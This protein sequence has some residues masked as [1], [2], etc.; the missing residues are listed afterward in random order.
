MSLHTEGILDQCRQLQVRASVALVEQA[1][2]RSQQQTRRELTLAVA[3]LALWLAAL[4]ALMSR[5]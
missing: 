3:T 2:V 4:M 1:G 5:V